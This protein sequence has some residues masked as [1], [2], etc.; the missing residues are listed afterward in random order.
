MEARKQEHTSVGSPCVR[1]LMEK[2]SVFNQYDH[3]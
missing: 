2:L 3:L 1:V